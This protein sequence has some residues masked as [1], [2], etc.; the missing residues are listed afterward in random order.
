MVRFLEQQGFQ[1]I[2]IRGAHHIMARGAQRTN[3]PVH[4]HQVLK[5]GTLRSILRD[6]DMSPEE[7]TRLWQS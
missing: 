2:R 3:V 6:I 1:V 4:G 7:F 5:I